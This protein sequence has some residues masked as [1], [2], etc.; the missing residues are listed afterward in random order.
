M[1]AMDSEVTAGPNPWFSMWTRPR[2]T[3]KHVLADDPEYWIFGLGAISGV[4]EALDRA[5]TKS[6]GDDISL[7]ALLAIA[8]VLG[9]ISGVV[10]IYLYGFLVTWTGRWLGGKASNL[11]VRTALALPNVIAGWSLLLWIP[12][13]VF[14][15]NDMFTTEMPRLEANPELDWLVRGVF[16]IEIVL[17][18]WYVVVALQCLSE[19]QG[20]SAWRALANAIVAILVVAGPVIMITLAYMALAS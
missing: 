17:G 4:S 19:V 8:V 14:L 6:L 5:S 2:R 10:S 18:V 1:M 16:A 7:P 11:E 9:A 15:G 13:F 12:L 20:F 3:L